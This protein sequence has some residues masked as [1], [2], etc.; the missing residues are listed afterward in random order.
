MSV[1]FDNDNDLA[2]CD[3]Y[4]LAEQFE[5]SADVRRS[6]LEVNAVHK[7]VDVAQAFRD[8]QSTVLWVEHVVHVLDEGADEFLV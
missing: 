1:V 6:R 7:R 2:P 8:H 3:S 4:V 5:T